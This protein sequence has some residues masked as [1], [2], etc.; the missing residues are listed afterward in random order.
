MRENLLR[1]PVTRLD[2]REPVVAKIDDTV[3]Q[4]VMA[5]RDSRLGCVIVVDE[6]HKPLGMFTEG[7]LRRMLVTNPAGVE[8]PLRD[9]LDRERIWIRATDPVA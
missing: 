6:D 1:E 9:H 3:R 5:M 4:A 8:D 7:M 2:L